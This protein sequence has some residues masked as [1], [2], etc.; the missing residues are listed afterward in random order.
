M[1]LV[2]RRHLSPLAATLPMH[3]S[4]SQP[5]PAARRGYTLVEMLITVVI[6]AIAAAMVIPSMAQT[7]VLR[8]QGALRMI[9]SDITM[10][11]SDAVAYQQKRAVIFNYEGDPSRY[12]VAQ[13]NG[14]TID[15]TSGIIA[16]RTFGGDQFGNT[17]LTSTTLANSRIIFDGLGGPVT[18]PGSDTAAAT[19]VINLTG[20]GQSFRITIDAYT[21]RV[22][23]QAL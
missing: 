18:D 10:A 6:L 17:A 20:S 16:D 7:G 13:I 2:A 14:S 4:A 3:A 12:V 22:T 9:V 1:L 21:G 5:L 15:L 8:V 11:Q 19:G 23:I